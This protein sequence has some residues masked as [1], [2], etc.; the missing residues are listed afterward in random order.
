[1]WLSPAL[2]GFSWVN[3]GIGPSGLVKLHVNLARIH[4]LYKQVVVLYPYNYD[5]GAE[6]LKCQRIT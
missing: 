4:E 1:M 3:I 6:T 5:F 2:I